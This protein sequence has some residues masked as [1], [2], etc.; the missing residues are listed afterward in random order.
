MPP[1][2]GSNML[3]LVSTNPNK[4]NP[5]F[6]PSTL[7]ANLTGGVQEA[8]VLITQGLPPRQPRSSSSGDR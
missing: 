3:A 8:E 6:P 2:E 7:G 1:P 4:T 5:I